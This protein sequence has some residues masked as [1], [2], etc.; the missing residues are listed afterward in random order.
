MYA[1]AARMAAEHSRPAVLAT[2]S[3]YA[4]KDATACTGADEASEKT[5]MCG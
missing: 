5:K 2:I 1:V 3:S 4:E